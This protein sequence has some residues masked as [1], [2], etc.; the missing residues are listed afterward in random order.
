M[1]KKLKQNR[2]FDPVERVITMDCSPQPGQAFSFGLEVLSAKLGIALGERVQN[3]IAADTGLALCRVIQK[4]LESGNPILLLFPGQ[5]RFSWQ[6]CSSRSNSGLMETVPQDF[7]FPR[8]RHVAVPHG[9]AVA[10]IGKRKLDLPGG[11]SR[12][13]TQLASGGHKPATNPLK[14]V[15]HRGML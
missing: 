11:C 2:I 9:P 7:P 3:F 14:L 5:V 4:P 6:A 10:E 13:G 1:E 8:G 12:V 15:E